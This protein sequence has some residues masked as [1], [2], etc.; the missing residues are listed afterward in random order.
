MLFHAFTITH[1]YMV[2]SKSGNKWGNNKN[3]FVLFS[4]IMGQIGLSRYLLMFRICW[5]RKPPQIE[6]QSPPPHRRPMARC[7]RLRTSGTFH[8]SGLRPTKDRNDR[9]RHPWTRSLWWHSRRIG[10]C[11][12]KYTFVTHWISLV[13]FKVFLYDDSPSVRIFT[14][15]AEQQAGI[16]CSIVMVG[17][18][19]R[20]G[21]DCTEHVAI[22]VAHNQ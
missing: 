4:G 18:P 11:R 12:S 7:Q 15:E 13:F 5:S 21:S 19:Q 8:C 16:P 14:S 20:G 2:W 6:W 17:W 22:H 9:L 3:I 1:S 10:C